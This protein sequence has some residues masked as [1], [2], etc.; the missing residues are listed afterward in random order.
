M[1]QTNCNVRFVWRG[2][3]QMGSPVAA[4]GNSIVK[5]HR[6]VEGKWPE[7]SFLRPVTLTLFN[8]LAHE[9]V[10]QAITIP[11]TV[12]GRV[13]IEFLHLPSPYA[14]TQVSEMPPEEKTYTGDQRSQREIEEQGG[15]TVTAGQRAYG[16]FYPFSAI[17]AVIV[18]AVGR[19]GDSKPSE[20]KS[21][22]QE[23]QNKAAGKHDK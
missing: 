15:P 3:M 10:L 6:G 13:T 21:S 2:K 11:F 4:M 22:E 8:I 20:S 16:F 18:D 7:H 14:S 23:P 5:L 1:H 17:G 9:I 19:L 12:L